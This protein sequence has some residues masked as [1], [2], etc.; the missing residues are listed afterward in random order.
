MKKIISLLLC[1]AMMMALCAC[2][3][4]TIQSYADDTAETVETEAVEETAGLGFGAYP[5]DTVV[6]TVNG[7]EVTWM[8]YFYWMNYYVMYVQQLAAAYGVTLTSWDANELSSSDDNATVVMLNTQYAVTQHHAVHNKAQELGVALDEADQALVQEVFETNA[9]QGMGDADGVCTEE[10]AAAFEAYLAEQYVDRAFFDYLNEVSLLSEKLYVNAYGEAGASY[11]D[12][13]IAAFVEEN[14]VMGAKHILLLTVDMTTGEALTED[15]IAAQK[16]LAE[17][18]LSQLQAVEGTAE[19]ASGEPTALVELFDQLTAEYTEDTGYA[20][21]PEGYIFGEGEMVTE[22]ED[23]VE[24]LEVYGLSGIVESSYGY[25]IILRIPVDP[26]GV[27]GT[28]SYG[29]IVTVRNQLASNQYSADMETWMDE[30]EVIW[31]EGF[32]SMDLA[33]IFG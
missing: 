27:L 24:A 32:E 26:D 25:H 6:G 10:E 11:P 13:E 31:N 4:S 8:E 18:L 16:A 28:D 12:E 17:D 14:G 9:D 1:L 30:A 2:G 3:G 20:S 5:A 21:Y 22:F 29:N 7:E 19:D 23:A 33:A 15:E